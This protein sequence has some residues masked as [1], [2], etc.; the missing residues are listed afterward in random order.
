MEPI[1]VEAFLALYPAAIV[2]LIREGAHIAVLPGAG[3]L[4]LAMDRDW[5]P[6]EAR[7]ERG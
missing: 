1:P 2:E 3:R 6:P 4:A 5:A 7:P